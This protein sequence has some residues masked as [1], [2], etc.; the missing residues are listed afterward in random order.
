[1]PNLAMVDALKWI[2]ERPERFFNTAK[3]DRV[4]LFSCIMA[5]IIVL[6]RGQC[7]IRTAGDWG[8]IGSDARWLEHPEHGIVELFSRIVV[9][10][11]HGEHS[12][13]GEVLVNAFATDV[14][15]KIDASQVTLVRGRGPSQIALRASDDMTQAILFRLEAT[16]GD[17]AARSLEP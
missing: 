8:I 17:E 3:P 9:E 16:E 4:H 10:P 6:A 7:V 12:M 2:R 13:R 15:V 1:M 5:D 11:D 14:A